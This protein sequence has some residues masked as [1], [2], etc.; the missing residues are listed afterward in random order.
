MALAEAVP[1]QAASPYKVQG[2]CDGYAKVEL[3]TQAG[4]CVGLV[5]SSGLGFPR[6]LA[7]HRG[8]IYITDLGSRLP[9]RGRLLRVRLDRP[10][11]PTVVLSR[12]DRPGAIV[13]GAD[14][15][16]YVA[17]SSRI[18]RFNPDAP[19]PA[20]SVEQVLYGLPTDGLHNL[21]GLARARDGGLFV[22]IG[23]ASDN[24]EDENG[25]PPRPDRPCPELSAKP[26]RGSILRLPPVRGR[27][28]IYAQGIRNALALLH[29]PSG[30]LLAAS[31]GRDNIDS[32]DP[33]LSDENLPHDLLLSVTANSDHGWPYCFDFDQPSPEFPK[34]RCASYARPAMLLPPHSAP[35]SML[36][37]GGD[38]LTGMQGKLVVAYH[39]YRAQGH[40]IVAF[41]TD[42]NGMPA[43][44]SIDLVAGWN[45][46]RGVRPLGTPVAMLE[47]SDGSILIL[48]DHNGTL[49]RLAPS[50]AKL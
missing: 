31:N 16:L 15:K 42:A 27:P 37:Y 20:K 38:R 44:P 48:E 49:L 41:A 33:S 6:G 19:D 21:P 45:A 10:W 13:K 7:E 1:A 2:R 35:L 3:A 12:L 5:G 26:P 30:V 23:S 17:E 14:G 8:D 29:L 36:Q 9:G 46:V 28:Q 22:S 39:G 24:C 18:F 32:A 50:A 47:R 43:G 4:T 25:R 40:R 34:A 11:K